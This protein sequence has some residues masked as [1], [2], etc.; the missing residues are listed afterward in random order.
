MRSRIPNSRFQIVRIPDSKF[1]IAD[2]RFQRFQIPEIPDSRDSR[3][4]SF[5][6]PTGRDE[7]VPS[8][9]ADG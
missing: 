1:G 2:S 4:G 7:S 5:E 9:V 6:K 8:A 3:F